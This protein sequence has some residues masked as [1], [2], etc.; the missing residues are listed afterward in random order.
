ML[1]AELGGDSKVSKEL[2]ERRVKRINRSSSILKTKNRI[3]AMGSEFRYYSCDISDRA[4][5]EAV[6]STIDKDVGGINAVIHGAG[7]YHGK[8]GKS[9]SEF[10]DSIATKTN[11]LF[12]LYKYFKD[13]ELDF[14]VNF[15]SISAYAG[16]PRMPDY[17]ANNEFINEFSYYWDHQVSYPVLSIM[18]AL[19]SE[20][21]IMKDSTSSI[22]KMGVLGISSKDGVTMFLRELDHIDCAENQVLLTSPSMLKV[23]MPGK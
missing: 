15:S 16:L 13:Y 18:W 7:E 11:S 17:S 12:V 9:V 6:L 20:V 5:F 3:E 4:K 21:G 19:W 10:G 2:L 14:V 1:A 22:E 8:K 23:S